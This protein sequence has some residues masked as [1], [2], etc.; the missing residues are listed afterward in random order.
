MALLGYIYKPENR[1][2]VIDLAAAQFKAPKPVLEQFYLTNKDVYRRHDARM[3]AEDL[4]HALT[5]LAE[6][7]FLD[8]DLQVAPYIDNAYL[9]R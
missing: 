5:R 9:P 4:Q 7:H 6:L 2:A 8:K 3:V 1:E